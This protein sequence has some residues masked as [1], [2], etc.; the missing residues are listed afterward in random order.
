MQY[1]TVSV[2]ARVRS[3][4]QTGRFSLAPE[5]NTVKLKFTLEQAMKA[6]KGSRCIALLSL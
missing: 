2:M 6:Q 3:F 1:V 4:A 5:R